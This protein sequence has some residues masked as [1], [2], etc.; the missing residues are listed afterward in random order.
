MKQLLAIQAANCR[1][2]N[3]CLIARSTHLQ[4]LIS[5]ALHFTSGYFKH[6]FE[7]DD[8]LEKN[9]Q[10]KQSRWNSVGGRDRV[11]QQGEVTQRMKKRSCE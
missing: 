3:T 2:S 5:L 8:L 7:K 9:R 10:T 6:T 1:I 11:Q 4:T